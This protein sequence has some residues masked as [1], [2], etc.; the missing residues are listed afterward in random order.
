MSDGE[1]TDRESFWNWSLRAYA[2]RGA[3][4]AL[5]RL[6]DDLGLNVNLVL[7]C[8]WCAQVFRAPEEA[9]VRKAIDVTG[10]W[11][12]PIAAQLRSARIALK[13][14]PPLADKAA[15]KSLRDA[16]KN[17]ELDAEKIEQ[18]M[19]QALAEKHLERPATGV[20]DQRDQ[21]DLRSRARRALVSYAVLMDAKRQEHFSVS[22]LDNA[23]EAIFTP[24]PEEQEPNERDAAQTVLETS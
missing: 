9:L 13:S 17:A 15:A 19:L 3:A 8:L 16:I 10:Q 23:V 12:A 24:E 6:Q 22:L 14:P 5:L 20:G 4:P 7:W 2:R 1:R 11:S 18:K 21:K